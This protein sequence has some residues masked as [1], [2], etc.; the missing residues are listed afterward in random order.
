[1]LPPSA[2]PAGSENDDAATTQIKG[3]PARSGAAPRHLAISIFHNDGV[4]VTVLSPGMPVLVGRSAPAD[5][6]IPDRSLSR[7]HARFLLGEGERVLLQDLKSTNGTWVGG[8]A[9]ERYELPVGG[10]ALLGN[11]VVR[12]HAL[13]AHAVPGALGDEAGFRKALEQAIAEAQRASTK[14]AVLFVRATGVL[15]TEDTHTVAPGDV[16]RW[17]HRV[18]AALGDGSRIGRV[19]RDAVVALAI[20][21]DAKLAGAL[22]RQIAQPASR[23]DAPLFVGVA[24]F[25]DAAISADKLLDRA[26]AAAESTTPAEPVHVALEGAWAQEKIATGAGPVVASEAMRRTL[27]LVERAAAARVPVVLWGET[28]TG[29]EVLARFLHEMSPRRDRPMVSVNCGAIPAQL[30]E[31]TLFGHERGA[32][33][34]ALAQQK[35][36]FEAADGGTVF[37]DEVGELSPAAQ[38]VL[39]RVL[40]TQRLTRVGSTREISVD[41]RLVAATHRDLERMAEEGRFRSDLYYRLATMIVRIPPLRDRKE[42]IAPLVQRFLVTG[43]TPVVPSIEP[44]A[45]AALLAYDWPGNVRELR[46]AIERALVV[47]QQ[48]RIEVVDLPEKI[49]THATSSSAPAGW[50]SAQERGTLAPP[51]PPSW[52]GAGPR[53]HVAPPPPPPPPS[54]SGGPAAALPAPTPPPAP[55]APRG[56][57]DL[58]AE[59][60]A[61]ERKLLLEVLVACD[62]NKTKAAQRLGLPLRTLTYKMTTLGIQRPER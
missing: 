20:G 24:P 39:L 33:T 14:L 32:F 54:W 25:P 46:N 37:L 44:D 52:S 38:A 62:W 48:S 57:V 53:A 17:V 9:V 27:A 56:D 3:D 49:Q 13:A 41:V 26:R 16:S 51:P 31:S 22:A 59:M 45:M 7:V 8:A 18:R 42:D 55:T 23:E 21:A 19:R 30:V 61:H 29:K 10:E 43:G 11:V 40:E 34:G 4:H 58:R 6:R 1:M 36:V 47:A 15:P 2:P 12:V 5:V 35:G 50:G 60:L 28:G